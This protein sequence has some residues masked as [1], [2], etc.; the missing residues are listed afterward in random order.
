MKKLLIG[1][2]VAAVAVAIYRT[3]KAQPKQLIV[4]GTSASLGPEGSFDYTKFGYDPNFKLPDPPSSIQPAPIEVID[5][6]AA[7][8]PRHPV[9]QPEVI[10]P[11]IRAT[12]PVVLPE[13][14]IQV[15]PAMPAFIEVPDQPIFITPAIRATEPVPV[16]VPPPIPIPVYV[17]PVIAPSRPVVNPEPVLVYQPDPVQP[18]PPVIETVRPAPAP[19]PVYV[20]P[21][22]VYTAPAYVAPAPAPVYIV[23]SGSSA[24]RYSVPVDQYE[25]QQAPS[26]VIYGL[27]R[28][29]R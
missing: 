27:G 9:I 18:A 13:Q 3:V 11:A 22:P 14:P 20:A 6:Y 4:G 7:L 16:F 29:L 10:T 15:T 2:G 8:V 23:P 1:L 25:V 12:E 19:E 24:P 28:V 5:P 26:E 21:A 17:E